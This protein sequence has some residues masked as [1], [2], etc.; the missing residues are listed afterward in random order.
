M[1]ELG[2]ADLNRA[3]LD[4]QHLLRRTADPLEHV[5]RHLVG[6]QAQNPTSPYTGLWS[7]RDGFTSDELSA[8]LLERRV[9]R[10]AVMRGT[11]HLLTADGGRAPPGGRAGLRPA[12]EGRAVVQAA[13]G[14][15]SA[16][17]SA[18]TSPVSPERTARRPSTRT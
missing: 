12:P 16:L 3:L 4:R 1:P 2:D 18:R 11:I 14:T 15:W 5:V 9:T 7:R 13:S 8:A 10:I 6:L 17:W